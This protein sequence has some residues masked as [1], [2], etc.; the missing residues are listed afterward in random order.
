VSSSS[1]QPRSAADSREATAD[2][3]PQPRLEAGRLRLGWFTAAL[4]IAWSA[5]IGVS[6]AW[7][8]HEARRV[9]TDLAAVEAQAGFRRDLAYRNWVAELGGVYVPT[10]PTTPPNPYL[11]GI[12][13]RDILDDSGQALTLAN[14]AYVTRLMQRSAA[15]KGIVGRLTSVHPRNPENAPDAWERQALDRLE[16][17]ADHVQSVETFRG[18]PHVRFMG[19][20]LT[21]PGCLRC[22][23]DQGYRVGDVRGGFSVAVRLAPYLEIARRQSRILVAC[24][25]G[26][27]ILGIAGIA[28]ATARLRVRVRERILAEEALREAEAEKSRLHER[29]AHSQRLE[30]LGQLAGGVAHDF[31]NLLVPILGA[32]GMADEHLPAGHPAR[33]ELDEIRRAALRARD[34]TRRLLAFG[35]KQALDMRPVDLRELVAGMESLLRSALG[36]HVELVLELDAPPVVRADPSQLETVLVNLVV[37]ARDSMQGGGRV[38]L[39]TGAR[40]ADGLEAARLGIPAGRCAVLTVSDS[41]CG[42]DAATAAR[43]FE[44]FFT[45]KPVGKGTGLG[46]S[47]AH[48]IVTQHG[49]AIRIASEPGR[50]TAVEILLPSTGEA[51]APLQDSAGQPPPRGRET[52]LV[53]EDD[54]AVGRFLTAALE[55]LGYR[56]VLARDGEEALRAADAERGEV[57]LLLSDVVMPRMNGRE[58]WERLAARRP[59][60]RVLFVSG[61]T[62]GVFDDTTVS[63][64]GAVVLRKP[65]TAADL[66]HAVRRA[67]DAVRRAGPAAA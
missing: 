59:G 53:A 20:M 8:L 5:V 33:T 12:P 22:H 43:A 39:A 15:G 37:N 54:P 60:L 16:A 9:A 7:N 56:V 25:G 11:A 27:W 58:L 19:R 36:S 57:H 35:R 44:P 31:N 64:L 26:F 24:H 51:A 41:G 21:E 3:R 52:I 45:T 65:F 42:M 6:L 28:L 4:A 29:L 30:A 17:G 34:L 10:S 48:G 14:P 63:A 49:G 66:G 40:S 1:T 38:T 23:E 13:H 32:S 2:A 55:G 47:T 50:G 61:Y 46:L 18:E 67:L 62:R